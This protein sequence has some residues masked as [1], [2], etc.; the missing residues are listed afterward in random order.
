MGDVLIDACGWVALIDAGLNIDSA[1]SSL[2]GPPHFILLPSVLEE[3]TLI[4]EKRN[5]RNTIMLELLLQRSTIVEEKSGHTDDLLLEHAR[6]NEIPLLTVDAN[7]KRR[8]FESSVD[9][10]EVMNRKTLRLVSSL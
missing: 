2:I 3:L 10:I 1:L 9:V 4:Q 6:I 5:L 7:L 8:C